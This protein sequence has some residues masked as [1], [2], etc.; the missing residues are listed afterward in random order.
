MMTTEKD[1]Y[2]KENILKLLKVGTYGKRNSEKESEVE[3]TRTQVLC[4]L[5]CLSLFVECI[6][7][8]PD[9]AMRN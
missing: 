6:C 7:D 1:V 5:Y 9:L 2:E 8:M 4:S 3:T